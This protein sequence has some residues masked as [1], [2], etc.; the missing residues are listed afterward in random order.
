MGAKDN[1][2]E[3]I[4]ECDALI[5][6]DASFAPN[7]HKVGPLIGFTATPLKSSKHSSE[8]ELI[9]AMGIDIHD[10]AIPAIGDLPEDLPAISWENFISP[11]RS[12]NARLIYYNR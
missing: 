8:K 6:D 12:N 5:L 10:S 11:K 1:T 2:I 9:A 3:I 7:H 4:D